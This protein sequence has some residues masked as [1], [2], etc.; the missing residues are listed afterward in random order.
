[1][2]KT[3]RGL[4]PGI[5][6]CIVIAAAAQ[7]LSR[8][9]PLA[10]AAL[11]AIGLGMAAG[12]TILNRPCFD[13]GTKFSE[14]RLLE[15]S[16]VLTGLTLNLNDIMG[17]GIR[18]VV[19]IFFQMT[20]T[21]CAAWLIGK[22]LGFGKKFTLLMCAGNA[23]C[24]S[25]AIGTVSPV[26]GADSKEKG[27]SITIVNVT[28]TCLMI[29][30]PLISGMLYHHETLQTSA[31]I[32]GVLQSIGQVIASAKLVNNNV[33]EMATI[34]KIIRILFLILVALLFSRVNTEDGKGLF[35]RTDKK[36]VSGVK[37][38]VPWFI[39]GFFLCSIAA[40]VKFIPGAVSNGAK[41]V[42]NQFEIIALAAI[43]MRVK[44]SDLIHEGPKAL[45][46]GGLTGIFQIGSAV[47]LIL[48]LLR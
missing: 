23:V 30:L 24:G 44:F 32:G 36:R 18:G 29:L 39:I 7:L 38:G 46:Y 43:G 10:G 33:V 3:I 37:I 4:L 27:I 28:G 14:S 22:R 5:A 20:V 6:C 1:M 8:L 2:T 17:V 47:L 15:Y 45:L 34:F 42:S 35:T 31:M 26:I 40:S 25:S 9:I 12:N 13:R 11:L 16:I 48:L 21:L 41:L 19:Y